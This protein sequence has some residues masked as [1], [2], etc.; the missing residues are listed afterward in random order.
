MEQSIQPSHIIIEMLAVQLKQTSDPAEKYICPLSSLL[1]NFSTS[2]TLTFD[3]MKS[4]FDDMDVYLVNP[5]FFND[6]V[7]DELLF[8]R[9]AIR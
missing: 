9:H 2:W 7:I 4:A 6:M 5:K 8:R 1:S 3:D